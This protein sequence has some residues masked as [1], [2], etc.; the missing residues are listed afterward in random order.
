MEGDPL[1]LLPEG[2]VDLDDFKDVMET[3]LSLFSTDILES[4]TSLMTSIS[5]SEKSEPL[6][7]LSNSFFSHEINNE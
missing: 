2:E 3:S 5:E 1:L 4:L 6:N 7:F